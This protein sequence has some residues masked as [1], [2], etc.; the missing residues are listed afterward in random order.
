[1]H[2]CFTCD[3]SGECTPVP[4]DEYKRLVV[5]EYGN[6]KGRAA[7]KAEIYARGPISC[8]IYAT[9]MLDAYKG[10][11]YAELHR[12]APAKINHVVSVVGWGQ[13]DGVE[14]WIVRNSWG[15]PWGEN[16]FFRIVT[17]TW[18]GGKGDDYNL[19]LEADCAFGVVDQWEPA[20]NLG[21]GGDD[22]EEEEESA[23]V[24]GA[25]VGTGLSLGGQ[26]M[27]GV[28]SL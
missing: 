26:G 17:S 2:E 5:S 24:A 7:M 23:D 28:A 6:I 12:N 3:P 10:G 4:A 22:A 25:S 18:K 14:F 27:R 9:D 21:Y 8:G 16:G 11:I 1:M 20:A 15:E 19:G 13:E